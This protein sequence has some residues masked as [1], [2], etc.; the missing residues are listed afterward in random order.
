MYLI[1]FI[2]FFINL[3]LEHITWYEMIIMYYWMKRSNKSYVFFE[4]MIIVTN[5]SSYHIITITS[6]IV[7]CNL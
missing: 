2:Y 1:L 6:R 4:M 5:Q 7:L 3:N